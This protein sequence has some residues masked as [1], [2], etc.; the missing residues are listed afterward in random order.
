MKLGHPWEPASLGL[1]SVNNW[2]GGLEYRA[3]GAGIR[4][5]CQ[6]NSYI[7]INLL[8]S[9]VAPLYA[10]VSPKSGVDRTNLPEFESNSIME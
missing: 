5:I 4:A 7:N 6:G 9:K 1:V 10:I 3:S 2:P 8:K